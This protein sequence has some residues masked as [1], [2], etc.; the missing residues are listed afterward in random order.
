MT[1]LW[2]E[3]GPSPLGGVFDEAIRPARRV[4]RTIQDMGCIDPG[5][6]GPEFVQEDDGEVLVTDEIRAEWDREGALVIHR[7][8]VG[9]CHTAGCQPMDRRPGR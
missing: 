3:S 7:R 4:V 9:N 5:T 6:P 1:T 8:I 2:P